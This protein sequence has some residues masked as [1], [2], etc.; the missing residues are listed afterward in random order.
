MY[1]VQSCIHFWGP[2]QG[3]DIELLEQV[4]RKATKSISGM[5]HLS[6]KGWIYF[7]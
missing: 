6:G 7:D 3:K 1:V 2:Q 4:Q 5:E